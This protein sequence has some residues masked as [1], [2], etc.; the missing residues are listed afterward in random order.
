MHEPS[1]LQTF[2]W[3]CES[4]FGQHHWFLFPNCSQTSNLSNLAGC[5]QCLPTAKK[6]REKQ[7]K[8]TTHISA[9]A[10]KKKTN[11]KKKSVAPSKDSWG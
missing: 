7:E 9:S 5:F 8:D 1:R 3:E 6:K 2:Q 4:S 10:R 11:Q